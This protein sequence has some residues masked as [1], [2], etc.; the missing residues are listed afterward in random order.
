MFNV[1]SV[2]EKWL[3]NNQDVI[4][5]NISDTIFIWLEEHKDEIY[6]IIEKS[7]KGNNE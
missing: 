3:K 1:D 4:L 2:I 7:S 6:T 5:K